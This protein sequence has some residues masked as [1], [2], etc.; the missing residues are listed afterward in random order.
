MAPD[1]SIPGSF[2][3]RRKWTIAFNVLLKTLAVL[4]VVLAVNYLGSRV[5]PHRFYLN[6]NTRTELSPRTRGLLQSITNRIRITVYYNKTDSLY[7][8][9]AALV[10]EY[11][12]LNRNI[13]V[14][15]IDYLNDLDAAVKVKNKYKLFAPT[16]KN[17]VIFDCATNVM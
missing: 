10:S 12:L 17:L 16:D 9:V 8:N 6:Q 13:T 7:D 1:P 3:P 5:F 14:E 11:S 2:S 15:K 4:L